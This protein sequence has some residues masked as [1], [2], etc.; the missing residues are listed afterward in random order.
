MEEKYSARITLTMIEHL[1]IRVWIPEMNADA[2][3]RNSVVVSVGGAYED[4][5]EL[6]IEQ[7][8]KRLKP[9]FT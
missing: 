5:H 4:F 2:D 7:A 3:I 6:F 8:A 9:F 1:S